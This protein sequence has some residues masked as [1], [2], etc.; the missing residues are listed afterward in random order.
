VFCC[1]F[2]WE[3]GRNANDINKQMF[4]V[5][6]GKCLSPNSLPNF[7]KKFSQVYSRVTDDALPVVEAAETIVKI[8]PMHW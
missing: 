6:S 4:P 5:Y 3:K 1:G 2:P 7:V 8:L